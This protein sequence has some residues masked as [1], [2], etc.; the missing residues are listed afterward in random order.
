MKSQISGLFR[1]FQDQWEPWLYC[2]R[3]DRNFK[4]HLCP[5]SCITYLYICMVIVVMTIQRYNLASHN[6]LQN[7]GNN[8]TFL[9]ISPQPHFN[10]EPDYRQKASEI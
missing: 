2:L 7:I 6:S 1:T 10:L 9:Y 4:F 5:E 8:V 3:P